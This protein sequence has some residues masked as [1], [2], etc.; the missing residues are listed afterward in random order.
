MEIATIDGTDEGHMRLEY[1]THGD[2][3]NWEHIG[4]YRTCQG[5]IGEYWT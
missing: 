1:T 3:W 4:N 5:H 2:G